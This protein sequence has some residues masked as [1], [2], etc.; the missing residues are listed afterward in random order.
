MFLE[1]GIFKKILSLSEKKLPLQ[2]VLILGR[3]HVYK[4]LK[5]KSCCLTGTLIHHPRVFD[6]K[7]AMKIY[8]H[9]TGPG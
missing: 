7:I 8:Q 9:S 3:T 6:G 2:Y 4:D 5:K 1:I